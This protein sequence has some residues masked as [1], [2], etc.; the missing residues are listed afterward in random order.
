MTYSHFLFVLLRMITFVLAGSIS[1]PVLNR[2]RSIIYSLDA[3]GTIGIYF[4]PKLIAKDL[5]NT[6]LVSF[7]TRG[8]NRRSGETAGE[9]SFSTRRGKRSPEVTEESSNN[10]GAGDSFT[11]KAGDSFTTVGD[12]SLSARAKRS[13]AVT[14][15]SSNAKEAGDSFAKEA[16]DS[17][18]TVDGDTVRSPEVI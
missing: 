2:A 10:K 14:E 4:F 7:T 13:P 17:F 1:G 12:F 5:P 16:G 11:K 6:S 18:T 15:E 8:D 9:F 3:L